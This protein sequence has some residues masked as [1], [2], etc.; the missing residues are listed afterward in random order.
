MLVSVLG[1]PSARISGKFASLFLMLGLAGFERPVFE[2]TPDGYRLREYTELPDTQVVKWYGLAGSLVGFTYTPGDDAFPTAAM[3]H[4]RLE[5]AAEPLTDGGTESNIPP[6][7]TRWPGIKRAV[8]G[9]FIP[10]RIRCDRTYVHTGIVTGWFAGAAAG[11]KCKRR[12]KYAKEKYGDNGFG[13]SDKAILY[14][15]AGGG[16]IGVILGTLV[17]LL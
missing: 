1:R 14:L 5:A 10:E 12:L 4:G 17:F 2:W 8:Y 7:Y 9:G 16:L 6:G 3:D 11:E 15:T 13:V